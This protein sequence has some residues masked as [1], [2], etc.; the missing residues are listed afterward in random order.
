MHTDLWG[1]YQIKS[2]NGNYYYLL[3]IDDATCHI[4]VNFLKMKSQAVQ[5]VKDYM[6]YLKVRGNFPQAIRMDQGTEFVNESLRSWSK[7]EGIQ[8][9]LTAGYSPSQNAIAEH[10]N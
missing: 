9:Q 10:M 6:T 8:L 4:T 1:K 5:K 7:A 3:L 2:V